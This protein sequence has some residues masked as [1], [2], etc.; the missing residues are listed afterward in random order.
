MSSICIFFV[1]YLQESIF[2]NVSLS[3]LVKAGASLV[4]LGRISE[5]TFK[6]RKLQKFFCL[7]PD[8]NVL[9]MQFAI[10]PNCNCL[11]LLE[12]LL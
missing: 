9:T 8:Q 7:Q 3:R 5:I 2:I 10:S 4:F 12:A 6:L 1:P 11:G